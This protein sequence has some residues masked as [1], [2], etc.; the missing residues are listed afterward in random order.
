MEDVPDPLKIIRGKDCV[1]RF[2]DHIEAEVKRLHS[3]Y[4]EQPMIPLTEVIERSMRSIYL[5]YL[6]EAL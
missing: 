2:V 1:E 5:P 6:H 4:P 3:L